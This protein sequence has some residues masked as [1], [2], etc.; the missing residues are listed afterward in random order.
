MECGSGGKC[1]PGRYCQCVSCD[2]PKL[3]GSAEVPGSAT[4]TGI[5]LREIQEMIEDKYGA[6]MWERIDGKV[7]GYPTS[8]G[9][10]IITDK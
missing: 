1:N 9:V 6:I 3:S 10:V 4:L 7:H 8:K 2:T 5:P